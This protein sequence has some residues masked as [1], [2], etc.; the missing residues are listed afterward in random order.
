MYVSVLGA[1][2]DH[3]SVGAETS[4]E[5]QFFGV[6]VSAQHGPRVAIKSVDHFHMVP[7][8]RNQNRVAFQGKIQ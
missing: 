4:L 3:L 6:F 5:R 1:A 2:E 7:V 8:R